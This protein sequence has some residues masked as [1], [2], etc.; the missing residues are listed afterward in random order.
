[1]ASLKNTKNQKETKSDYA[2]LLTSLEH[3][4]SV[5]SFYP[6][7]HSQCK[8]ALTD[9]QRI[10]N[11]VIEPTDTIFLEVE[12]EGIRV[13]G[14]FLD[15][16]HYGAKSLFENF[17][18]LGISQLELP[19][20]APMKDL[21]QTVRSLNILRL[22][23]DSA[24]QF[25]AL[26][27]SSIPESVKVLQREF[28]WGHFNLENKTSL[29]KK[30]S[31]N[32][33]QLDK[34]IEKLPWTAEKKEKFRKRTEGFLVKTIE[35][36][37]ADSEST[38]AQSTSSRRKLE[39][40]LVLGTTAI[41]HTIGNMAPNESNS[42]IK[43]LFSQAAKSLSYSS[44][45]QSVVLMLDV[46]QEAAGLKA[47]PSED[48]QADDSNTF[49]NDATNYQHTVAE[50]K[51]KVIQT[52][53]EAS[54]FVVPNMNNSEEMTPVYVQMLIRGSQKKS[55]PAIRKRL[56]KIIAPPLSEIQKTNLLQTVSDLIQNGDRTPIDNLFPLL[57]PALA[58]N[59]SVKF[60][61]DM[62]FIFPEDQPE[63][64]ALAWPHLVSLMIM[65][66]V[67]FN[68][69]LIIF[70]ERK[71]DHLGLEAALEEAHRLDF[72]P[73]VQKGKLGTSLIQSNTPGSQRALL[74]LMDGRRSEFIGTCI[75][76]LRSP[77]QALQS[78]IRLTQPCPMRNESE[79]EG[80]F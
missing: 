2:I 34:R 71:L 30:L 13:Q 38:M 43:N 49:K 39:D 42:G 40:V 28:G 65:P 67:L 56:E 3:F 60:I 37:N 44:D 19:R 61:K 20:H 59:D 53:V 23:A 63:K 31:A 8:T 9:L 79:Q 73:V 29:H 69:A 55:D 64:L 27:F 16:T 48:D 33:N 24:L 57:L 47:P 74:A 76:E 45:F 15:E 77:G 5:A 11:T 35:R 12:N 32:L 4:F 25:H 62:E 7:N 36:M 66:S 68:Q 6:I 50:L 17:D 70:L 14:V 72:L 1:M 22:E 58:E 75:H 21:H 10:I 78:D 51:T 26:D 54:E 80:R 52:S 41:S 18:M 46:L